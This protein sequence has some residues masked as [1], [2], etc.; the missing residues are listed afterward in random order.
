MLE[1][2]DFQVLKL[3]GDLA[4]STGHIFVDTDELTRCASEQ[5]ISESDLSDSLEMLKRHGYADFTRV[6]SGQFRAPKLTNQGFQA[7]T[8]R[9]KPEF[10]QL[11]MDLLKLIATEDVTT[12][13]QLVERLHQSEFLIDMSLGS[14]KDNGLV[15][16]VFTLGGARINGVT[17]TG[18]RAAKNL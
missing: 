7:Y 3:L 16:V 12:R 13:E 10:N 18:R 14:L 1:K 11:K 9:H 17:V 5:G 8:N 6:L 2:A 15:N 4:V